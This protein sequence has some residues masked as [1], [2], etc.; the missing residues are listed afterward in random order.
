MTQFR[1]VH[2]SKDRMS[3]DSLRFTTDHQA[4]SK[5]HGC[6]PSA[7]RLPKRQGQNL[8]HVPDISNTAQRFAIETRHRDGV[9]SV[10]FC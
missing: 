8:V 10:W 6:Q 5:Y 4:M 7:A 3:I 9:T 1:N 2:Y